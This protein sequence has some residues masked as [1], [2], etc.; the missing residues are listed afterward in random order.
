MFF[1]RELE[2]AS[3]LKSRLEELESS[4]AQ[5]ADEQSKWM[6]ERVSQLEAERNGLKD[7]NDELTM[8]VE[9]LREQVSTT[10]K[11]S[12]AKRPYEAGSPSRSGS[13]LSDYQKPMVMRRGSDTVSSEDDDGSLTSSSR[14]RRKLPL[15]PGSLNSSTGVQEKERGREGS[16]EVEKLQN[17]KAILQKEIDDMKESQH[18]GSETEKSY[19]EKL[20]RLTRNFSIERKDLE[21]SYKLEIADLEEEHIRE[22]DLLQERFDKEKV[23]LYLVLTYVSSNIF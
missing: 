21:Q 19:E 7:K 6:S 11:K 4:Q 12:R 1:Q 3:N 18:I 5:I 16:Q 10:R 8:E 2:E 23:Q 14:T 20:K 17:E 13:L 9:E 22:K 15:A